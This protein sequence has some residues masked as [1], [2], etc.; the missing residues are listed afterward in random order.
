[1]FKFF[2]LTVALLCG[3]LLSVCAY[4]QPVDVSSYD[5]VTHTTEPVNDSIAIT[6][7]DFF[8][9][10]VLDTATPIP[11]SADT[12]DAIIAEAVAE[13]N[14]KLRNHAVMRNL[15]FERTYRL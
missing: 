1:M 15:N 13:T 10:V 3:I 11:I 5:V 4:A 12:L 7:E 2:R 6:P 8:T 14:Y 9:V